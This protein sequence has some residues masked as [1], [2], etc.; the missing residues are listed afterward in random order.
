M[1]M[2]M[3]LESNL[4]QKVCVLDTHLLFFLGGGRLVV[5]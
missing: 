3:S 1:A 2:V 4:F 5:S